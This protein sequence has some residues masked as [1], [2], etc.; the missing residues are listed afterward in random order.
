MENYQQKEKN[1][2]SNVE[3]NNIYPT[4]NYKKKKN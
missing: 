2:D 1:N 3:T 4:N